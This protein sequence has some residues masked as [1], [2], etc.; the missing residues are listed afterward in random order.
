[1]GLYLVLVEAFVLLHSGYQIWSGWL[2]M[3]DCASRARGLT[4]KLAWCC[5]H[6]IA[7]LPTI[8]PF[9]PSSLIAGTTS[10]DFDTGSNLENHPRTL[11]AIQ[12]QLVSRSNWAF[13]IMH[14]R[15]H[16]TSS[17]G[18]TQSVQCINSRA[19]SRVQQTIRIY[20]WP[21]R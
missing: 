15:A 2:T 1:M 12:L 11:Q 4:D 8:E 20:G 13:I 17:V 19:I 21:S 9:V 7:E 18:A 5:T 6:G 16:E 14:D 10:L 3:C